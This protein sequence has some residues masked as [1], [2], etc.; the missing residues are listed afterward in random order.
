M[1]ATARALANEAQHGT[2][3]L[4]GHKTNF[5]VAHE[6]ADFIEFLQDKL[7]FDEVKSLQKEFEVW[8]EKQSKPKKEKKPTKKEL[9]SEIT[10][11]NLQLLPVDQRTNKNLQKLLDWQTEYSHVSWKQFDDNWWR[12]SLCGTYTDESTCICYAR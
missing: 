4:A 6:Y 1:D 2:I 12:C 8:N 10:P 5:L 3:D 11:E 9:F 7:G